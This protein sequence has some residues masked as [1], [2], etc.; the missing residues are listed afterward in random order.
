VFPADPAAPAPGPTQ[1]PPQEP[2][3]PGGPAAA[4]GGPANGWQAAPGGPPAAPSVSLPQGGGAIRDI[5]EKFSVSAAT[6]TSSLAIPVATSPGRA[7]FGP[8]L[9]L[10][11]DSGGG[12]GPFGLGWKMTIP[13]ITRKTDKGL[14]RY[15]DDPDADTFIL[16]GAED[17]VPVRTERKAG[18]TTWSRDTGPGSRACSHG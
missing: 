6:G 17:L 5:G 4:P 15:I 2:G 18:A 11:Y 16:S 8:S 13:A 14:P 10:S 9:S 7:G 3:N 12:N 1:A